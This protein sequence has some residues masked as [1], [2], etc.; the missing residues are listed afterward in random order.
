MDEWR[1]VWKGGALRRF[2]ALE[3]YFAKRSITAVVR[4]A[5]SGVGG[6]VILIPMLH[7]HL[8]Q[9]GSTLAAIDDLTAV[10]VRITHRPLR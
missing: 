10:G 3:K 2:A 4:G 6:C 7:R 5:K 1:Y 8:N 9:Q